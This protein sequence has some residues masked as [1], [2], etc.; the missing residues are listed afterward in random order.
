M[1]SL[2]TIKLSVMESAALS[3]APTAMP[4]TPLDAPAPDRPERV[5]VTSEWSRV[6]VEPALATTRPFWCEPT[7]ALFPNVTTPPCVMNAA[8]RAASPVGL[9][10]KTVLVRSA[11]APALLTVRPVSAS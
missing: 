4:V 10:V 8:V 6:S 9:A 7:M 3:K 5:P 1:T 11:V 2:S